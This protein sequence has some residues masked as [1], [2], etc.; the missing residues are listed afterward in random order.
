[1]QNNDTDKEKNKDKDKDKEKNK[2]LAKESG[3]TI[4]K[5]TNNNS[6]NVEEAVAAHNL[7]Q[8][9]NEYSYH[10]YVL[11]EPL[12]PDAEYDRLFRELQALEL[13]HPELQTEDSPTLRVGAG[14]LAA[15]N[16]VTHTIPMLSLD[17]AFDEQEIADF[18]Q[19]IKDRLAKIK[20]GTHLID[21]LDYVCEPKLDGLAVTLLYENG[22]LQQGATRGDG[23][24]GEDI[25]ENLRTIRT[26]PL[27]L[28][29]RCPTKLIVRGE[30]Y[31][32]KDSFNKLN[33][34]AMQNNEKTFANPRNAAAGSL[35]QLNS[36]IT[37][38]RELDFFAYAAHSEE[39]SFA[40]HSEVLDYL[41]EIGFAINQ[42]NTV[43]AK[44]AAIEKFY[45]QILLERDSLPYE[46]D[47]VVIKVNAFATQEELG[48]V[49]RAPRWA[50][51]YKF[52]AQE[53][54]TKL[55]AV[56]FQIG[57]TGVLTPVA[58]LEPIFVGGVTVSNATLHN[59]N[60]IARKD[61]QVGDMVIVR[62]AGDVIPEV[63]KPVLQHRK[64]TKPIQ[65]PVNCPVCSA[66]LEQEEGGAFVRCVNGLACPAQL[67]EGIKHFVSRKAMDIDGVGGKLIEQLVTDGLIQDVAD[68]YT[69]TT[70]KLGQLERMGEKS[71]QN[72]LDSLEKSKNTKFSNLLYAL[73]IREVG[74]TTAYNLARNFGSVEEL[75]VADVERLCQIKDIGQVVAQHIHAFFQEQRNIATIRKLKDL[76]VEWAEE[77]VQGEQ[78]LAGLTYVLTGTLSSM[79]RVEAKLQLQ[80]LG[81]TVSSAVSS[82]T[83]YLVAGEKSGSKLTKAKELQIKILDEAALLQLLQAHK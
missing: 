6:K 51:A 22:V 26:V 23:S 57:R 65:L 69:L 63:V 82:N 40:K 20:D 34:T 19:R 45:Q 53:E 61:I 14:P 4:T 70:E 7:R 58:R 10:Y 64:D 13:A 1:M 3:E 43:V 71:A 73:G 75:A 67:I 68:L 8:Q 15:F 78:P 17:N 30:V 24:R 21:N 80:A 33:K 38:Q 81:A 49:S 39:L 11:D 5:K 18:V 55:L 72:V 52:P 62:R 56:D 12:V 74:E 25:T 77:L 48:F 36:K 66:S 28:R 79:S 9:L 16:T 31:M 37:A 50:I 47:G 76:G 83:D 2:N 54:V 44:E 41:R 59:M 27:S 46:I 35:R 42:H 60:E 32:S 29:G